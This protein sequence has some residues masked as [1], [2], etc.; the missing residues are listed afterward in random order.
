MGS[1]ARQSTLR[2]ELRWFA[3]Q[4]EAQ[5]KKNDHKGGWQE[6]R[7]ADLMR[8]IVDELGE[9]YEAARSKYETKGATVTHYLLGQLWDLFGDTFTLSAKGKPKKIIK[10]LTDVANFCMMIA[11][12]LRREAEEEASEKEGAR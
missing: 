2:P 4:M 9:V 7:N 3:E 8:R 11:D 5:L 1:K 10:E 12:N 6:D